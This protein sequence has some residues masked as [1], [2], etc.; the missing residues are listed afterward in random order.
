MKDPVSGRK[1][2]NEKNLKLRHG[3]RLGKYRLE[4]K[5]ATGGYCEIWKARDTIE[6]QWVALKIPLAN[7]NGQRDNQTILREVRLI[8]QLRHPNIMPLKTAEIYNGHAVLVTALSAGTLDDCKRPMG[9]RRI[10]S[11]INQ[12]LEGLAHAHQHKIVHCDVTPGNIFLF[13][14][15]HAALG[16]FGIGLVLKKRMKTIEEYGTP[17]YVAPE[18]AYGKPT[19]RSD[20]FSIGLILYE[21]LTGTLPKWPFEWPC[22]GHNRLIERTSRD[23]AAFLK[24]SIALDPKKRFASASAMLAAMR[25]STPTSILRALG[26]RVVQPPRTDWVQLRRD[27]FDKRY[28]RVF[29]MFHHCADCGE[30]ITESMQLCPWCGSDR[31]RFDDSTMLTHVCHHCRRGV[32]PEWSYCPWCYSGRFEP[33]DKS[34]IDYAYSSTRCGKCRGKLP[35]FAKYCPWC[36]ARVKQKWQV[37]PFP[38]ICCSCGSSVDSLYWNYCPWCKTCL[39]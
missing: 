39:L 32:L 11:I 35:R 37:W 33:Q 17:G 7:M 12:V 36:H 16:D 15:D 10:L 38:D 9:V 22:K 3:A 23:F 2:V 26:T 1:D 27:T 31:N 34:G 25:Q 6:G 29:T 5:L 19:Y 8:A 28:Q 18:Q 13:P 24:K 14:N 21:Y 30:P 4:K 20:C